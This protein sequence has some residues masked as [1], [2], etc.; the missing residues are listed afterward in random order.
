MKKT[1]FRYGIYATLLIVAVSAFN[2]FV[3]VKIAGEAGQEV[4]GYLTMLLS[5]IFVFLGIRHFR[6]HEN[7]GNLSFGEGLKIGLLIVLIPSVFFG[8]F[9]LLYT[10]VINP[11]WMQDYYGK[12]IEKL[13]A[14]TPP[15]QL[16]AALKAANDQKNYSA[17]RPY[18]SC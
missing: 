15:D 12:Y 6:D 18:S 1:V 7:A 10:E 3:L 8:L 17:T 5:M 2:M 16:E 11:G 4:A 13:K 9:D 14:S